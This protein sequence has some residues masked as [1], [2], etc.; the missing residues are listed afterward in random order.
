MLSEVNLKK[1]PQLIRLLK[2]NEQLS[3]LL[4]LSSE[5]LLLRWFNYH[6]SNA[7]Y[8]KKISNFTSDVKDSERYVI[9]LNQLNNQLCDKSALNET[10]PIKKY[11]IVFLLLELKKS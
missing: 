3:D 11:F 6:L 10:D 5:D 9:L 7:G 8:Q 1:H 2:E 4:K